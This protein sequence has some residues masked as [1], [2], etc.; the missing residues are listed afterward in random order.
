MAV[1]KALTYPETYA[2]GW[3]CGGLLG[4]F[5]EMVPLFLQHP[6]PI[7]ALEQAVQL[8][9]N[10]GYYNDEYAALIEK[11]LQDMNMPEDVSP[12]T[13]HRQMQVW[14][15]GIQA[16]LRRERLARGYD[17]RALRRR[18]NIT[19]P[20][21]AEAMGIS[22]ARL[23]ELERDPGGVPFCLGDKVEEAV[24]RIQQK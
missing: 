21:L 7:R 9:R 15:D 24:A 12:F 19:I 8:S 1:N 14:S 20:Q 4:P 5:P 22:R 16:G 13:P 18:E 6:V 10:A 3:L 17:I 2:L 11:L 23:S